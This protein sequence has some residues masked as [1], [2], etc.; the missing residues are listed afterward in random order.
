MQ[1]RGRRPELD[2]CRA[3]G[4]RRGNGSV[5]IHVSANS[6]SSSILDML[7]SHFQADPQSRYLETEPVSVKR[8]DDLISLARTDRALLKLDV[9][10]YERQVLDGA[11]RVLADCRAVISEMSL[12][13]MYDGELLAREMWIYWL[14]RISRHGH[15]TPASATPER[16]GTTTRWA[17]RSRKQRVVNYDGVFVCLLDEYYANAGG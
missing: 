1:A 9:Q 7:P 5:D 8:L 11:M 10:G 4:A 6:V 17:V 16:A 14:L 12:V 3:H 13:P 2:D 15:W